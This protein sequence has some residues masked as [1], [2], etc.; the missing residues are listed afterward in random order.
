MDIGNI[1]TALSTAN[2]GSGVSL[3]VLN[4]VLNLDQTVAAQLAASIGLGVHFDAYA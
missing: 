3:G 1:A 2:V 4:S